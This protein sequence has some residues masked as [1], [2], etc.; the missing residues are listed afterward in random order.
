MT[1]CFV[2]QNVTPH[3]ATFDLTMPACTATATAATVAAAATTTTVALTCAQGGS[4]AIGDT[5]PG[6]GLV[7]Y[8]QATGTFACG[9]TLASQCKYLE[10]APANWLTGTTGDPTRT[11]ATNISSNQTTAVTGADGTLIGTGYQNSLDIVAQTGNVAA[12]SAAV[13]ARAYQGNSKTDWHLP[14]KDELN[15]MCKWQRGQAWVSDATICNN[16]GTLNSGTGASGFST[17]DFWS[18]S[19]ADAINAWGQNFGNG[20]QYSGTKDG[21]SYVRP[22]RAF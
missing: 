18:S 7:F 1:D 2:N 17:G 10:A 8:V 11:W 5:G 19:E 12:T 15:Q 3:S 9:A 14:S 21:P 13:E 20:S 6:G 22:V 4:C 16:T